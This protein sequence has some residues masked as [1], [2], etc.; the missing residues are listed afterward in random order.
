MMEGLSRSD[1][2]HFAEARLVPHGC[3]MRIH[4]LEITC[5][6]HRLA[7][8]V[9]D[10]VGDDHRIPVMLVE[11]F[12]GLGM[13]CVRRR[14]PD[15]LVDPDSLAIREIEYKDGVAIQCRRIDVASERYRNPRLQSPAVEH[16]DHLQIVTVRWTNRAVRQRVID[17]ASGYLRRVLDRENVGRKWAALRTPE[18]ERRVDT[19]RAG[20]IDVLSRSNSTRHVHCCVHRE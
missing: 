11:Y 18:I 9:M 6:L 4:R 15:Q 12:V 17:P 8:R 2:E 1:R 13:E 16:V 14:I 20:V 10:A 19:V 5:R 7:R 3:V